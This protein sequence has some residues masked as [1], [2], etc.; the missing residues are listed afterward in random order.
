MSKF[1]PSLYIP[2]WMM[3]WGCVSGSTA[4]THNFKHLFVV[5]FFLGFCEAPF[6]PGAVYLLSSWY[7]RK[8]LTTRTAILYGGSLLSGSFGSLIA[9]GITEDMEG[10]KG[11]RAWRWLFIIEGCMTVGFAAVAIFVLPNYPYNT[12]WLSPQEKL[13]AQG[14]LLKDI[15]EEDATES[16]ISGAK[17]MIKDVKVYI[18]TLNHFLITLCASFTNFFPTIV[19]TL[20]FDTKITYALLTPPYLLAFATTVI[21]CYHADKKQERVWHIIG[22]L[23]VALVGLIILGSTLN[24]GARYFAMIIMTSGIYVPYDTNLSWVSN[25]I[26]RTASK[27]AASIAFVNMIS[28]LG[29][30]SGGYLFPSDQGPRYAMACGVLAAAAFLSLFVTFGFGKYLQREN[31]KLDEIE[32]MADDDEERVGADGVPLERGFRYIY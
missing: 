15:G 7:T 16:L 8:E 32:G 11:L 20:G 12:S 13:I 1:K 18:L 27:R 21:F 31:Q 29:N 24:T 9:L 30:L 5:R 23:L 10:V 14:R 6:F 22:G 17:K 2:V 25:T 4:A 28:N 19:R 3:I 26:Q